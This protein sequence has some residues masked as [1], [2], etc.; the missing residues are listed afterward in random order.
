LRRFLI[1]MANL[2]KTGSDW[3]QGQ[4][5]SHLT[6]PVVYSRGAAEYPLYATVG[7]TQYDQTDNNGFTVGAISIDF[8]VRKV[9]LP[10]EPSVGDRIEAQL[11]D[12]TLIYEVMMLPMRGAWEWSDSF[13]KTMRIHTKQVAE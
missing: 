9:D 4:R 5:H 10:I 13:N 2:L 1:F 12:S 8:L 3:L 7:K 6:Q 11:D